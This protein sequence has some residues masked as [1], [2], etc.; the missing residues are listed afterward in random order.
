LIIDSFI[1][2]TIVSQQEKTWNPVKVITFF[3]LSSYYNRIYKGDGLPEPERLT[4]DTTPTSDYPDERDQKNITQQ[5]PLII[6]WRHNTCCKTMPT[7][8][9]AAERRTQ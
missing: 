7:G 8:K 1:R 2:L 5:I 3:E 9:E 6:A 4:P